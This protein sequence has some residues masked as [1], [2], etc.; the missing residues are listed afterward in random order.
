MATKGHCRDA[1]RIC[2]D[3]NGTPPNSPYSIGVLDDG[4]EYVQGLS[5]A[6]PEPLTWK[7]I[8]LNEHHVAILTCHGGN[9]L[10]NSNRPTRFFNN[11]VLE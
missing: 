7:R 8:I 6:Y 1:F 2:R 3:F 5:D 11:V 4:T 9:K 10:M